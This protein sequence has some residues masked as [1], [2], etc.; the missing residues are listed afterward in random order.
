MGDPPRIARLV[1]WTEI[2]ARLAWATIPHVNEPKLARL[3]SRRWTRPRGERFLSTVLSVLAVAIS[4]CSSG[5][6]QVGKLVLAR[7]MACSRPND[8]FDKRLA[9]WRQV[10]ES[11]HILLAISPSWERDAQD[12]L[13]KNSGVLLDLEIQGSATVRLDRELGKPKEIR[14]DSWRS[15]RSSERVLVETLGTECSRIRFGESGYDFLTRMGSVGVPPD[16]LADFL[17]VKELL[18]MPDFFKSFVTQ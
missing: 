4:G 3:R 15:E 5:P 9:Y 8:E 11:G 16:R 13:R 17:G 7:V 6:V 2:A 10:V 1:R 18:P 14:V 12:L